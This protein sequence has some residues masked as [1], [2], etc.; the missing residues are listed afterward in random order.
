M[1]G[2]KRGVG[3]VGGAGR[4]GEREGRVDVGVGGEGGASGENVVK[5]GCLTCWMWL[6]RV[7]WSVPTFPFQ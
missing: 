7:L 2:A 6:W 4:K 3:Q 1:G 5:L